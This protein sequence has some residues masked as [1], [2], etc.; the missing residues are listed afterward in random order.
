MI[1]Y[2]PIQGKIAVS[3]ALSYNDSDSI[4]DYAKTAVA[5][6]STADLLH[7]SDGN[8]YPK[9]TATRAEAAAMIANASDF[10]G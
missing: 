1:L 5:S 10:I 4:A 9:K 3:E 2:R 8:F 6:L 7:G